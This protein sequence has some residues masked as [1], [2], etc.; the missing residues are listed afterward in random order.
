M[1]VGAAIAGAVGAVGSAAIG[2]NAASNAADAAKNAAKKNNALQK[3]IYD[4]NSANLTPFMQSG[5]RANDAI[6][7]FLGLNGQ[8]GQDAAFQSYAKSTGADYT[9]RRGV[10][11]ITSSAA[12]RGMLNSGSTLKAVNQFARDDSQRY[13]GSY[14]DRLFGL[15]GQGMGAASA[16]AGVGQNYAGAVGAN[17][18]AAAD[19][20][21]NA[22]LSQANIFNNLIGQ[23]VQ[24][25]GY[26]RG[27]SSYGSPTPTNRPPSGGL[28]W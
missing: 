20:T 1:P 25:Y 4:R 13:V 18:N 19:V 15:S 10:D 6:T 2:A 11:A 8:Q 3:E 28:G 5:G 7:N 22:A 16:L 9:Q 27:Q 24:A 21:G 17:N 14:L 23:G 26:S 12:T